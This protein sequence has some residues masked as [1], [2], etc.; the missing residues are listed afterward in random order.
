MN[1]I[2]LAGGESRRMGADK[3][4]LKIAGLPMIEHV[5]RAIGTVVSHIIVV[6]NSPDVY[7]HYN[8]EVTPDAVNQSGSLIGIYS[9]LLKSRDEYNFVVAC[10]MPF[11]SRDLLSFMAGLAGSADVILPKVEGFV[12]PLHAIYRRSLL[13][14]IEEHLKR[15][16]RQIKRIFEGLR[17]RYVTEGEVDRFDPER[18]SF[19]N[20]NRPDEYEKATVRM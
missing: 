17:V 20:L 9:G 8:V 2:V 11:L 16:Q 13:P 5:F 10:D 14:V 6:T 15:E 19:V 1:G 12:E 18:R 4:F 7:A 3:A